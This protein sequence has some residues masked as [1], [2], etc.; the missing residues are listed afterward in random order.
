[1]FRGSN[2][3]DTCMPVASALPSLKCQDVDE[4]GPVEV[5]VKVHVNPSH[6]FV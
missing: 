4:I 2:V 5:L 6:D 1:L 3:R